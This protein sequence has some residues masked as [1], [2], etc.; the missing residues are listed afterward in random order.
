MLLKSSWHCCCLGRVLLELLQSGAM[1]AAVPKREDL[2]T[3]RA[4]KMTQSAGRYRACVR[5]GQVEG[6]SCSPG[7]MSAARWMM[8]AEDAQRRRSE[9]SALPLQAAEIARNQRRL[10]LRTPFTAP[11]SADAAHVDG[12][13]P[14]CLAMATFG[15][16]H[17]DMQWRFMF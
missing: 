3:Q 6:M 7:Q 5:V 4:E 11:A 12:V 17:P 1:L 9:G 14:F 8:A 16:Q 15:A 2:G 13:A 10:S